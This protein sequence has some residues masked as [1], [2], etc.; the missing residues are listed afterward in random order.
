MIGRG[1]CRDVA[2]S[3]KEICINNPNGTDGVCFGDSGGPAVRYTTT[4]VPQLVGGVSRSAGA[5]CGM[6]PT[7]FTSQPHFRTWIYQIARSSAPPIGT[8]APAKTI[9]AR[10]PPV[11]AQHECGMRQPHRPPARDSASPGRVRRCFG[12]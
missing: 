12:A 3:A 6:T 4:G 2:I 9:N 8:T 1:H 5:Y 11:T 7:A 10:R